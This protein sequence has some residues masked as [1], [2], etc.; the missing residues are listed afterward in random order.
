VFGC[1]RATE[2]PAARTMTRWHALVR[3]FVIR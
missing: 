2:A 3:F 1:A